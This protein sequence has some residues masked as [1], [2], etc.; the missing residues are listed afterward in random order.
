MSLVFSSLFLFIL[1]SP[2]LIFRF[3]YLQGTYAKLTFKVSAVEEIFWALIPALFLQLAAILV[4]D[5]VTPYE[6]RLEVIYQLI[7]SNDALDFFVI[8]QSLLPF[9]IYIALLLLA[10]VFFGVVARRLVRRY[11]LDLHTKF[12]RFG[13]EWHYLFSG[14]AFYLSKNINPS[15]IAFIQ[16]DVVMGSSEGDMIYSG[17]LE[18]YY[19]SRDNNGLDRLYLTNVYRRLLKNDLDADAPNVGFLNRHLDDRYYAM[20]GDL[21]VV[22][23]DDIKNLNVTY[24][25]E[26][27]DTELAEANEKDEP[28]TK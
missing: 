2:G 25:I 24:M 19:L 14:E 27:T 16:I 7:T 21:F 4:V 26:M 13:N 17:I 18:D 22:T 10:S 1:I 15:S 8:E 23:Y 6:V 11:R 20:P 12:L 28:G 3:S 5:H 9:L